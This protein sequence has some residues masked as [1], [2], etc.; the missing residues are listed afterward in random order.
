MNATTNQKQHASAWIL[1]TLCTNRRWF[2]E[3]RLAGQQNFER[4]YHYIPLID[5]AQSSARYDIRVLR[6]ACYE[7]QKNNHLDIWGDDYEPYG[8]LVQVTAE[9]VGA[10]EQLFYG[11]EATS[12]M[13]RALNIFAVVT[14]IIVIAIG[15]NKTVFHKHVKSP[16]NQTQSVEK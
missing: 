4:Q 6:D 9:G 10:N 1:K 7:L 15:L 13:K 8:M 12:I 5:I 16:L 2:D 11:K 14:T 3:M